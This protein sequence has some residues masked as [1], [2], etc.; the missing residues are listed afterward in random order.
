[1]VEVRRPLHAAAFLGV[2]VHN[3]FELSSGVGLMF[4]PELGLP[5]ASALWL[6]TFPALVA[7]ALRGGRRCEAPL[8]AALGANLAAV[9]IHY[10][11]W[12]WRLRQGMPVLTAAEGLREDQLPPY[13]AILLAWCG[14]GLLALAAEVPRRRRYWAAAGFL[15]ALPLRRHARDH[16]AWVRE[17]SRANP[18]W[19]NRGVREAQ[20][21]AKK[22]SCPDALEV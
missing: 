22:T 17:Q 6:V 12:P 7:G 10:T 20:R 2:A 19:W 4:Q 5:G 8:A 21:P 15:A 3:A 14:A 9:T 11:L 18:A 13:N 16:F 1:M